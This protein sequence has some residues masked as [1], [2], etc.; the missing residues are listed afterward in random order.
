VDQTK[1]QEAQAA[2]DA[3]DFRAA[4][5]GFLAS[6]GRGADGNGAAYHM[7]GN[8][9]VRLRRYQDALTVY[10]H[11]L[12]DGAYGKRGAVRANMGAAYCELGEYADAVKA[13]REAV[14]EP[15]YTTPYKA[16]QGM[17]KSLAE[18]GRV[19]EAAVAYRRAALDHANPEP[20]KSL[21][22]LGLC[23]MA[24]ERPLDAIEAYKAALGFDSYKARG[25]ALSN[26]GMA[27]VASA[28]Y[29]EAVK[30]FDKASELH[31]HK[32]SDSAQRALE[33]A[34]EAAKPAPTRQVVDGWD[35]GAI[36]AARQAEEPVGWQMREMA[37]LSGDTQPF[38]ATPTYETGSNTDDAA[39]AAAS[40][41]FGD[42]RAVTQFFSM[43]EDEMKRRDR[44]ERRAH[45][46][47]H[48]F[49]DVKQAV[50][51][52]AAAIAVL[53]V[54]LGG[55]YFMGY[56]WPTQTQTAANLL[57]AHEHGKPTDTFWVA[58]PDKDV[59]REM[60]K[61]PPIKSYQIAG[62]QRSAQHSSVSVTVTPVKGA[63]LKYT[64][65]LAR[66]GVGWKVTGVDNDW[67]SSG[68]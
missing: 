46:A 9:L 16:W 36:P 48:G 68:N 30:A 41:G 40:L 25:K 27:Y 59:A 60:A 20:G 61:I 43:T 1:F 3:G 62:V 18:R 6:A 2:Y 23:F 8:A 54:L 28:Q 64:L 42:D 33:M 67:G 12:R 51:R 37:A 4:A 39:A 50:V 47:Q 21:V 44:E 35:T 10:G 13:Y 38:T 53:L 65:T 11:A 22:N 57:D 29:E 49:A 24:L 17:A 55:A 52:V 15:D 19:E 45:R 66:E 63:A 31:G 58:V 34:R 14:E 56:G 5:K 26:L 7:A 32:L